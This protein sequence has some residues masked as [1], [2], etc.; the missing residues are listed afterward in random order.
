M[1]NPSGKLLGLVA[2]FAAIGIITATG[3]F[4][5][6]AAERTA[7][8]DVAGDA[9]GLLALEPTEEPDG[10][11]AHLSEDGDGAETLTIDF[12]QVDGAG[13]NDEAVTDLV[14]VFTITNNGQQTV[15]VTITDHDYDANG[16]EES[17][18]EDDA[19]TFYTTSEAGFGHADGGLESNA[20]EIAPGDSITV[21]IYIDT[22]GVD[23]DDT[24]ENDLVDDIT[25]EANAVSN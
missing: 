24:N 20:I 7:Q 6:V 19:V 22:R 9:S 14:D 4:T 12:S 11:Y 17:S 2:L 1:K 16:D 21:S 8:I 13:V 3:A 5:T 15:A 10:V 18:P 25:I 23:E